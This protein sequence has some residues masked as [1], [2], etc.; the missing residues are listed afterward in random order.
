MFRSWKNLEIGFMKNL[1]YGYKINGRFTQ[2]FVIKEFVRIYD[3]L[4]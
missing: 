2:D 4:L 1:V 3:A